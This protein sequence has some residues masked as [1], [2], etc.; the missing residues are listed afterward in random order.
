MFDLIKY[1]QMKKLSIIWVTIMTLFLCT[2][3]A[4]AREYEAT[5]EKRMGKHYNVQFGDKLRIN[6]T[7]GKVHINTWEKNEVSVDIVITTKAKTDEKAE[8]LMD[9]IQIDERNEDHILSYRTDVNNTNV[10]NGNIEIDYTIN[11]PRKNP[12]E[13]M[14]KFGDVY[15]DNFDASLRMEVTYGALRTEKL[16]GPDVRIKV[17]F[18]SATIEHLETGRINISYSKLTIEHAGEIEVVN[19][20]GASDITT[21][22]KLQVDQQ[23]GDL[24]IETVDEI[25]GDVQFGGLHI[26]KLNKSADMTLKYCGKAS[27]NAGKDVDALRVNGAF[28]TMYFKFDKDASLSA[29]IST[30]FC[31]LKSGPYDMYS[32]SKDEPSDRNGRRYTGKIGAGKGT[33]RVYASYGDVVFLK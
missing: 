32:N 23:Y 13:V 24:D 2:T 12:L 25:T 21:V 33:M 29:D 9:R 26:N 18:G 20:F 8:K 5:K 27:I 17:S 3:N 6:N 4:P 30:S 14:N 7:Y 11:M 10:I 19:K 22:K 28:S 31:D 1:I 16:I 15:L